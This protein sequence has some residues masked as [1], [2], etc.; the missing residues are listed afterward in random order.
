MSSTP[1]MTIRRAAP[2]DAV[3]LARLAADTFTDTFGH[4]Y[5]P[6]HLEE[7]LTT[8]HSP[9]RYAELLR[10]PACAVWL[11]VGS[12]GE[13]VGF[14]SVGPCHLPVENLEPAAGELRQLY[15]RREAQKAKIG[16]QLLETALQW[17]EESGYR[18]VYLG[19]WS[20]NYRA[21]R[22]YGRYGFE[23]VGEYGFRVGAT[24]DHE[25]ILRRG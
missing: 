9:E 7:F 12:A 6:E 4:L 17:L 1:A 8:R 18:P 23:K 2:E 25:F 14:A 24:V 3:P 22:L 13:L 11:A 15:V 20:E 19:V 16:T 21:Q 5:S 10:D